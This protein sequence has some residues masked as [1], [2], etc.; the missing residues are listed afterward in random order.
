[1]VPTKYKGH[2]F[3]KL[4]PYGKRVDLSKGFR[5]PKRKLVAADVSIIC[6]KGED[7]SL[8]ILFP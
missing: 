2:I 7:I 3:A 1:M 6:V 4:G 8:P 5:N